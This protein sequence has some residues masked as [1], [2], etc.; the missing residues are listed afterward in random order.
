MLFNPISLIVS[1]FSLSFSSSLP[2][3]T[4]TDLDLN[5]VANIRLIKADL[6]RPCNWEAPI[7]GSAELL[8]TVPLLKNDNTTGGAA[9]DV[10]EVPIVADFA[11]D[12]EPSFGDDD[13]CKNEEIWTIEFIESVSKSNDGSNLCP[14]LTLKDGGAQAYIGS[15]KVTIEP[16]AEYPL[17]PEYEAL[18]DQFLAILW[19]NSGHRH[20]S[21]S[22]E[23]EEVPSI[24]DC[25][26]LAIL[27]EIVRLGNCDVGPRY[28]F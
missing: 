17:R 9:V 15:K 5:G 19:K 2:T 24:V 21:R 3:T 13:N 28:G 7:S 11:F 6:I 1:L 8:M 12:Y 27:N 20:R 22:V 10:L 26:T 16:T 18:Y 14:S 25:T 23:E 4:S